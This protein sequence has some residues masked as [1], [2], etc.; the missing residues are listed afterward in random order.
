MILY[1]LPVPGHEGKLVFGTLGGKS[2]VLMQ[3]RSHCYEGYPAQKVSTS[4][5][6]LHVLS[7]STV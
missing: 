7:I 2:V 1:L 4:N 3:G 6:V 5:Y